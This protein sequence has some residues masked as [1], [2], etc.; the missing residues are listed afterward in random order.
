[1]RGLVPRLNALCRF[2]HQASELSSLKN[3]GLHLG[4]RIPTLE[5]HGVG[6]ILGIREFAGQC[7]VSLR[8]LLAEVYRLILDA[9]EAHCEV[10]GRDD[11]RFVSHN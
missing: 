5:C 3:I 11:V 2:C 10:V 1:M 6:H 8:V 4:L 7:K 9:L